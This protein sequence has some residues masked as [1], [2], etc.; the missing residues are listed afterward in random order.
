[1]P[2][3]NKYLQPAPD[4]HGFRPDHSITLA[5]LQ[6]PKYIGMGFNQRKP[7]DGTICVVVDLSAAL[8]TVCH[9]NLLPRPQREGCH[10]ICEEDKPR[11][12]SE[13]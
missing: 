1:M 8:D 9:N 2:T 11:L 12:D 6:M 7:P 10:V 5:L 13:V 3:V 4:Q